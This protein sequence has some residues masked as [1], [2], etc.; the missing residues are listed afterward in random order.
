M[1][2]KRALE[3]SL[4]NINNQITTEEQTLQTVKESIEKINK[5]KLVID[6]NEGRQTIKIDNPTPSPLLVMMRAFS[7]AMPDF[8]EL[9]SYE[10]YIDLTSA[11]A[12]ITMEGRPLTADIN[13]SEKIKQMHDTLKKNGWLI[14]DPELSFE[15]KLGRSRFSNQ[16]G[17]K[18][19]FILRF[20]INA[21]GEAN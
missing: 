19:K 20:Q 13:L 12:T 2:K 8:V 15:K 3:L 5:Y 10:G 7:N 18:R 11:T 4:S 14:S 17:E 16:Q 6:F 9:D 21:R 1:Q